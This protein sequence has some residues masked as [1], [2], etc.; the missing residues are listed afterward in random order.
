MPQKAGH[1]KHGTW[2]R[3]LKTYPLSKQWSQGSVVCFCLFVRLP[4]FHFGATI[5]EP[6]LK[7]FHMS[8]PPEN[9]LPI[10]LHRVDAQLSRTKYSLLSLGPRT[11]G[12]E[13]SKRSS[14]TSSGFCGLMRN[15]MKPTQG[16]LLEEP[17]SAA[18][19]GVELF[20]D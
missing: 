18:A 12:S 14:F 2:L 8:T 6:P 16:A 5:F 7:I 13:K 11:C 9:W 1:L 17:F 3:K 19:R 4:G 10:F 15:H 20:K